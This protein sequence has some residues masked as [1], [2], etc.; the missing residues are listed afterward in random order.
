MALDQ[1]GHLSAANVW[2]F[3]REG[4]R[5][6]SESFLPVRQTSM[7]ETRHAILKLRGVATRSGSDRAVGRPGIFH[8]VSVS[9]TREMDV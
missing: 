6:I 3:S 1:L 7:Q 4:L 9:L 2:V 5:N 8:R